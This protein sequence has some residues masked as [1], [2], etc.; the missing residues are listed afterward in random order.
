MATRCPLSVL[1]NAA[2][3]TDHRDF[4]PLP[5]GGA[6]QKTESRLGINKRPS[7]RTCGGLPV[8]RGP[9]ATLDVSH[10]A[11]GCQ[12]VGRLRGGGKEIQSKWCVANLR[13]RSVPT[14]FGLSS[15]VIMND[16]TTVNNKTLSYLY[17]KHSGF[18]S[19][20]PLFVGRH[21]LAPLDFPTKSR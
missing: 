14:F 10:V 19:A 7:R 2:C 1:V 15:I 12:R 16:C 4:L 3:V 13:R 5:V 21:A 18:I 6:V 17:Y 9:S 11:V 20:D 8:V